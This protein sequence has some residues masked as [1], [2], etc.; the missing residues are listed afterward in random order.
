M[1]IKKISRALCAAMLCAALSAGCAANSETL[2]AAESSPAVSAEQTANTIEEAAN[3]AYEAEVAAEAEI[4]AEAVQSEDE[5]QQIYLGDFTAQTLDS[6]EFTQENIA[7]YDVTIINFWG[8]TCPPCINEMPDIAKLQQKLE[9]EGSNVALITFCLDG[10]APP[11]TC[12]AILDNAGYT[13]ITLVS[14]DG[15]LGD[16]AASVMYI[17]TT[18]FFYSD[19]LAALSLIGG[20]T[21]IEGEYMARANAMIEAR[22]S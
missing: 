7:E 17:P 1:N 12:K 6:G 16:L 13:G 2:A 8:T 4:A 22:E 9:E 10:T 5:A 11:D 15:V 3:Y 20:Q 21:D 19:G 14:S 18:V